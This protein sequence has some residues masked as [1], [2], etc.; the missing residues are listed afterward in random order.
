[1]N[2][3]LLS[4]IPITLSHVSRLYFAIRGQL[5]TGGAFISATLGEF[6]LH[7]L[8]NGKK[9]DVLLICSSKSYENM[10]LLCAAVKLGLNFCCFLVLT[11]DI[12]GAVTFDLFL[13]AVERPKKQSYIRSKTK[14][15][16]FPE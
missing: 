11:D 3:P 12:R 8:L 7:Q 6:R 4:S 13:I 5:L 14:L 1:V 2:A 10:L 9:Y 16:A 15:P